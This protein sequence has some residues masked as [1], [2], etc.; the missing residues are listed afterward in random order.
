M[1]STKKTATKKTGKKRPVVTLSKR[2][3]DLASVD[4]TGDAAQAFLRREDARDIEAG[5]S[6]LK[7]AQELLEDQPSVLTHVRRA[8]SRADLNLR[9][10]PKRVHRLS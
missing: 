7:S 9:D 5:I 2:V 10:A 3:R 8:I 4:V 1:S 6:H